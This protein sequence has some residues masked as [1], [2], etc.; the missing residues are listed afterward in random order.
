MLSERDRRVL[1]RIEAH[2]RETDPDL[3]RLFH[4]GPRRLGGNGLPRTLLIFGLVLLVLGC[5]ANAV[6]VALFGVGLT[7]VALWAASVNPMGFGR[8]QPA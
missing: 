4:D 8:A 2:L 7:F 5:V 6:P 3:V 1:A